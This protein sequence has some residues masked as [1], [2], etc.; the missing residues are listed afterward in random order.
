M[1]LK[2]YLKDNKAL[3]EKK[4]LLFFIHRV[5]YSIS[6]LSHKKSIRKVDTPSYLNDLGLRKFKEQNNIYNSLVNKNILTKINIKKLDL[7]FKNLPVNDIAIW[8]DAFALCIGNY[9]LLYDFIQKRY[10][11]ILSSEK[12]DLLIYSGTIMGIFEDNRA[13]DLFNSAIKSTDNKEN[14]AIAL[15]RELVFRIKRM[16]GGNSILQKFNELFLKVNELGPLER[17]RVMALADN[18]YGLY[19]IEEEIDYEV[20]NNFASTILNNAQILLKQ[21]VSI[22]TDKVK[23]DEAYR[24][25]SQVNINQAQLMVGVNN[26]EAAE[27]ILVKNLSFASKFATDYI[28][29]ARAALSYVYYLE[30][31]LDLSIANAKKA[32]N[33][34]DHLGFYES[35]NTIK[36]ILVAAYYKSNKES[37]AKKVWKDIN[38]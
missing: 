13:I 14:Q 21:Y 16:K 7:E 18:L 17:L 26:F 12:Y 27:K 24:Y 22:A 38:N 34:F 1:Y 2:S 5:N 4:W 37:E 32:I 36:Q 11:E 29:E 20:K 19:V 33:E 8:L 15:H 25:L 9:D 3:F 23:I 10:S 28:P 6:I 30:N 35:S 31:K